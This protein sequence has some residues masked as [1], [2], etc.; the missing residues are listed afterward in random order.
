MVLVVG[1]SAAAAIALLAFA[2]DDQD[3]RIAVTIRRATVA[4]AALGMIALLTGP[5]AYALQT[6]ATPY[7]GGDPAAGPAFARAAFTGFGDLFSPPD[8]GPAVRAVNGLRVTAAP[9]HRS[10]RAC[11]SPSA[12]S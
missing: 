12:T 11:P 9:R 6:M 4:A 8:V 7:N 10:A 2:R 3:T 5:A 1:L